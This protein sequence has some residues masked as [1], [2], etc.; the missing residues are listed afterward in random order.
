MDHL[1]RMGQRRA[2]FQ[3]C[4]LMITMQCSKLLREIRLKSMP[5]TANRNK[6]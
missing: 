5:Q 3:S 6:S 1:L 4:Q 2:K